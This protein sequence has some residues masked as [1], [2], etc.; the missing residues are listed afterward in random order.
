MNCT[1]LIVGQIT[2]SLKISNIAALQSR[3]FLDTALTGH[4]EEEGKCELV[5][6]QVKHEVI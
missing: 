4:K 1:S 6:I 2:T 5:I 3:S